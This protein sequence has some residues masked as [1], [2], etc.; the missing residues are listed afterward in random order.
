LPVG[1][2]LHNTQKICGQPVRKS[3]G[4]GYD[5]LA[6]SSHTRFSRDT[7][8]SRR[9]GLTEDK[10]VLDGRGKPV[11][12]VAPMPPSDAAAKWWQQSRLGYREGMDVNHEG[13]AIQGAGGVTIVISVPSNGRDRPL[14]FVK[15]V[16]GA[17]ENY[18]P[19]LTHK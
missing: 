17:V 1:S 6:R 9:R 7:E 14:E 11:M 3:D 8:L 13:A 4:F 2:E 12:I 19:Q 18:S 5:G 16:N 15:D 10:L